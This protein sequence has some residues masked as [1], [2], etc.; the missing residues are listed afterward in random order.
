MADVADRETVLEALLRG[1]PYLR[2]LDRVSF[3]RLMGALEPVT[4]AA[5]TLIAAEGEAADALYL[6]EE[7]RVRVTVQ[8]PAGEIEV[9]DLSAPAYFGEMGLLLAR[10]TGSMRAV[11]DLRLWRMPRER[12]EALVRERP[13]I[14]LSVARVLADLLDRRQRSL[15]GA[16]LVE[17]ERPAPLEPRRPATRSWRPRAAAAAAAIAL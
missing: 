6:L 1:V 15:I 13:E 8:S 2:D 17:T 5:G 14:A 3:A 7:G 16:P 11:T 4:L 10:R 9:A 12:F